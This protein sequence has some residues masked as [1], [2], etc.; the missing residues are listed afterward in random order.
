MAASTSSVSCDESDA[1]GSSRIS[2]LGSQPNRLGD[3]DHLPLGRSQIGAHAVWLQCKAHRLRAARSAS[4]AAAACRMKPSR[5]RGSSPKNRFSAIVRSGRI[6]V[7]CKAKR[8]ARPARRLGRR[9]AIACAVELHVAAVGGKAAGA[10][11]HQRRFA[12]PVLA[13]ERNDLAGA[14]RRRRRPAAHLLLPKAFETV[15]TASRGKAA[16]AGVAAGQTVIGIGSGSVGEDRLDLSSVSRVLAQNESDRS[17]FTYLSRSSAG[18]RRH[19][20]H[21]VLR[22]ALA[23]EQVE[24]DPQRLRSR[25][26][27]AWRWRSRRSLCPSATASA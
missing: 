1:V 10:D 3:L 11:M 9:R 20:Q 23:V 19:R 8:H 16:G 14:Q 24:R 13:D 25:A 6:E 26:R 7:S 2:S 21:R 5:L 12:R 15:A 18:D 4:R 22:H 17:G 27:S